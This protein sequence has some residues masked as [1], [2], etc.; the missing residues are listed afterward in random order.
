MPTLLHYS[1]T[2][3]CG[4]TIRLDSGEPCLISVAQAGVRVRKSRLGL[5]GA[6]LYEETNVYRAAKTAMILDERFPDVKLPVSITNP[7][8]RAFASAAWSCPSAA[9]VAVAINQAQEVAQ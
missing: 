3:G 2:V 5:F 7:V 9:A 6:K 4:M 8:L 1:E